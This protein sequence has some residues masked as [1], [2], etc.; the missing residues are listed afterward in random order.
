MK[1]NLFS[2][3][4]FLTSIIVFGCSNEN[5]LI[6]ELNNK[7][8]DSILIVKSSAIDEYPMWSKDSSKIAI[9]ISGKW[10]FV[11]FDKIRLES[12]TWHDTENI[13]VNINKLSIK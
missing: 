13:L 1:K 6:R 2:Y 7:N 3:V 8:I 9:N 4:I 5:T 12:G 11:D 10:Y